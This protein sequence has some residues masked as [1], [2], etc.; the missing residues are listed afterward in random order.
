MKKN[1][2]IVVIMMLAIIMLSVTSCIW[3][4]TEVH[5]SIPNQYTVPEVGLL[6]PIEGTE[7]ATTTVTFTWEATPGTQTNAEEAAILGREVYGIKSY[8][9][10]FAGSDDVWASA[11]INDA[12]TKEYA[13]DV[14]SYGEDYKWHVKAIGN[15]DKTAMTENATFQTLSR[16]RD[17]GT[18]NEAYWITDKSLS[19]EYVVSVDAAYLPA[20]FTG[21][22]RFKITM[23][24]L[25]YYF[26][27]VGYDSSVYSTTIPYVVDRDPINNN[28]EDI[29]GGIFDDYFPVY[30]QAAD[31]VFESVSIKE[32]VEALPSTAPAT[33]TLYGNEF[34]E[35]QEINI[36][37]HYPLTFQVAEGFLPVLDGESTRTGF[38][39]NDSATITFKNLIFTNFYTETD[40]G[41]ALEVY[42][43]NLIILNCEFTNNLSVNGGAVFLDDESPTNGHQL[44]I[45]ESTLTHNSAIRII[46][47]G[48]G[49]AVYTYQCPVVILKDSYFATNTAMGCGGAMRLEEPNTGV[50]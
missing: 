48:Y 18:E 1:L 3:K 49:G 30:V 27:A 36:H 34:K 44:V 10:S 14:L 22:T 19:S 12:D 7:L 46:G 50:Y 41:A 32:A 5:L 13:T 31:Q 37:H 24:G 9:V 33:I 20:R 4:K 8:I 17:L 39:I 47:T 2:H 15:D 43:T 21:Q 29:K 25:V 35:G 23:N 42:E 45:S 16:L 28:I 40:P 26:E 6:S 38:F 11:T